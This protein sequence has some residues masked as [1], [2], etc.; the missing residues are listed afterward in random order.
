M[1]SASTATATA[2]ARTAAAEG[3]TAGRVRED[4]PGGARVRSASIQARREARTRSRSPPSRPPSRWS[5]VA[6]RP[7]ATKIHA[8]ATGSRSAWSTPAAWPRRIT[9]AKKSC[10]SRICSRTRLGDHGVLGGLGERL[11]PEVDEPELRALRHVGVGDRAEAA[12][13]VLRERLLG[14]LAELPPRLVEAGEVE[15]ALRAEVP[16]E[17]RLGDPRLAGD[18]GRR[19]AAVALL[20]EDPAG[21][22]EHRLPALLGREPRGGGRGVGQRCALTRTPRP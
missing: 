18:L 6:S 15:V 17:D 12:G 3:E 20:E 7:P 14:E 4:P 13:R 10:T 21:G 2:A 8:S 16:V 11:D 5:I 22:V 1:R 19:R 9:S